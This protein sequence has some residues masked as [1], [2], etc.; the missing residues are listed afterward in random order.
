[1]IGYGIYAILLEGEGKSGAILLL[2]GIVMLF[3]SFSVFPIR[4]RKPSFI[5]E[6]ERIA[7]DPRA[8]AAQSYT[9]VT[10]IQ[11]TV[12]TVSEKELVYEVDF[13][14]MVKDSLIAD[15]TSKHFAYV[16]RH[17]NRYCVIHNGAEEILY[18]KIVNLL[19]SND[20]KRLAYIAEKVRG[21]ENWLKWLIGHK[22]ILVID[23]IE[24]ENILLSS[25]L[26]FSSDSKTIACIGPEM[27]TIM[28]DEDIKAKYLSPPYDKILASSFL[29]S[30]DS[31]RFAFITFRQTGAR[32]HVG[33]FYII[34][35]GTESRAYAFIGAPVFSLDNKHIAYVAQEKHS[36]L[37]IMVNGEKCE[38][39][40][41][42]D[43]FHALTYLSFSP[44]GSSIAFAARRHKRVYASVIHATING[45]VLSESEGYIDFGSIRFS[46]DGRRLAFSAIKGP[47]QVTVIVDGQEQ[48][49]FL[50]ID[51][52]SLCFS[53][54]GCSIA[55]KVR[56]IIGKEGIM[57]NDN[58]FGIY[59]Y[60]KPYTKRIPDEEV[61]IG[62]LAFYNVSFFS[63]D[64]K[65][66][67]YVAGDKNKEFVCVNG[68]EGEKY[69]GIIGL[70][71]F[72]SP[73]EFHYMGI[74]GNKLYLI[75][76]RI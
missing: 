24:Y 2:I 63:P 37:S 45:D 25:L 66:I 42:Y 56:P 40:N 11:A 53:P 50:Y 41:R 49:S 15:Q 34:V 72:D 54:D 36:D 39:L 52:R 9:P 19:F 5:Q 64:S 76:E 29:F 8:T 10:Q 32:T 13:S 62:K 22:T 33:E 35:D 3:A 18:S 16:T 4:K 30:P 17:D 74:Q 65:H 68:E 59:D 6:M 46:P 1:M 60:I 48:K 70:P 47:L 28:C 73:S 57:V 26:N 44:N 20:G 69:D 61:Q 14:L 67:I 55:Y 38:P 27:V 23:K 21:D 31:K 75:R 7:A 12:R 51:E 71:C 43:T 58:L